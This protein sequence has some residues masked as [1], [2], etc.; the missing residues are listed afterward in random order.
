MRPNEANSPLPNDEREL[1]DPTIDPS[2]RGRLDGMIETFV[3]G[4]PRAKL[5]RNTGFGMD[6][7]FQRMRGRH[8]PVV[9]M[10]TQATRTFGFFVREAVFVAHRLDLADKTHADPILYER[11]GDDVMKLLDRMEPSEKDIVSDVETLIGE[12]EANA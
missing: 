9:E 11:Y 7:P 3:V 4:W 12:C 1:I 2:I 10:R 6:P 8:F 5:I